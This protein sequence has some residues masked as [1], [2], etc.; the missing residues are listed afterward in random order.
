[1]SNHQLVQL[2]LV[3]L[4]E[5]VR[6]PEAV[7]WA[8]FFPILLA[9][10]LGIAFAGRP[11]SVLKVGTSSSTI[12]K[13][14]RQE[15]GL[16][17]TE[18][19]NDDARAAL[20][21]GKIALDVE[22]GANGSMLFRYDNTSPDGR[23]AR[24][25]AD[26]AIQRAGGRVDPVT[27][28]DEITRDP[29]SRYIDFLVPGLIGIGIMSNAVWGLGFSIVDARR[30]KLTKRLVATPMSRV[31]F[32]LSYLIWRKI[33]L[34]IEVGIPLIF[35]ALVFGVPIRGHWVDIIVLSLLTSFAFSAIGLLIASRA[36]TIEALSGMVNLTIMPM[37]VCSGVFF[38]AQRFPDFA[39]PFIRALPL[40]AFIDAM[41][42]ILL[43]G[44]SLASFGREVVTLVVWMVVCFVLAL[45]LFRWR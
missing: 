16:D 38:S 6:E 33:I 20:M 28:A 2:V 41:R 11:E 21:S 7:F 18:F 29:G 14:L 13:A 8:V 40:T 36:K 31:Q 27:T 35:G 9:A 45:K 25:L 39:Q 30:R 17:V 19:G 42:G 32:L 3:R 43:Q 12:A 26:A 23:T 10:G 5:F 4:R 37:W 24:R 1:M 44:L 22:P 34:V 15:S